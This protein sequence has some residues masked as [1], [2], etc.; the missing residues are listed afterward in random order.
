MPDALVQQLLELKLFLLWSTPQIIVLL[1]SLTR[2]EDMQV[3]RRK[4]SSRL[5]IL[6][7]RNIQ[8][9]IGLGDQLIEEDI[10]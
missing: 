6:T 3:M 9:K 8:N 4:L 10:E 2:R 1:I 5:V 7:G